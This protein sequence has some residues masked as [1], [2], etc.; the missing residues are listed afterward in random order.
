M[1]AF[2][3]IENQARADAGNAGELGRN[4]MY[5]GHLLERLQQA[6]ALSPSLDRLCDKILQFPI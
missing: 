4:F 5:I 6:K 2:E 3:A 1:G